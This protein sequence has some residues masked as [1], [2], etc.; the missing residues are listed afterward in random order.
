MHDR[1]SRR[2]RCFRAVRSLLRRA[3]AF[4]GP[5]QVP[6]FKSHDFFSLPR[7]LVL[8]TRRPTFSPNKCGTF[9]KKKKK[10]PTY[11]KRKN[12][13]TNNSNCRRRPVPVAPPRPAQSSVAMRPR[14]LSPPK[15][16]AAPPRPLRP[17]RPAARSWRCAG[18]PPPSRKR[19]SRSFAASTSP[20]ARA[21]FARLPLCTA[22]GRRI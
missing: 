10:R 18:S 14:A 13:A 8:R 15:R 2:L 17:S 9:R 4:S 22:H 12:W 11:S 1:S 20:S 6:L 7:L 3:A 21:R 5:A 16:G 19:A